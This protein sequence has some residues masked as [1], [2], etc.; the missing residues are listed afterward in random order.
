M[1]VSKRVCDI[2]TEEVLLCYFSTDEIDLC[3]ECSSALLK[4][5]GT[6]KIKKYIE[7]KTS[8]I[9]ETKEISE[10]IISTPKHIREE[11]SFPKTLRS[12]DNLKVEEIIDIKDL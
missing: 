2:C 12:L 9:S 3:S 5:I 6:E 11:T 8:E 10:S 4:D 1:L 7:R